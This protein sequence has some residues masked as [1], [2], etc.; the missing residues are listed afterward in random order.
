MIIVTATLE[1]VTR[2]IN[3]ND[4]HIT[5]SITQD[6][7]AVDGF[8]F[9]I[10]PTNAGFDLIQSRK[11]IIKC[12]NDRTGRVEF[13]GR[14]LLS[15][16]KMDNSGVVTKTVTC[17][18]LMGYLHDSVQPY[19]AEELYTLNDF[20]DL[21]LTNH[22]D[23]VE[24]S[25]WIFRGEVD[26]PVA[27]TG[28]VYKGLQYQTTFETLKTKLLDVYGG[29]MQV[30]ERDGVLRLDYLTQI[31][32][33]RSTPI[34]L[35]N[36]MLDASRE[37]SPLD[38]VTRVIPLGAKLKVEV[39]TENEDGSI[40]VTEEE[41]E[42]RLTLVGHALEDG[43]VM[44]VPWVDDEEK[45]DA[46]GVVVGTLD[47][48][49]VTEQYNLYAKTREW[50]INENRVNLSHTLTAID[51]KE[52]GYDL[53]GLYCGDSYPVSNKLIGLNEVLRITKKSFDI[54]EQYKGNL[55]IGEKKATLSKL[56]AST[57]ERV[58]QQLQDVK[59]E[60][61]GLGK[62]TGTLSS[63]VATL[64]T[65]LASSMTEV[66]MAA[67][68]SYVTTADMEQI[69][70]DISAEISLEAGKVSMDFVERLERTSVDV[71]G[72]LSS[73]LAELKAYIRYYM[74]EE[75]KPTIELGT[76]NSDIICTLLNDKFALILNGIP[77]AYIEAD[78][79]GVSQFFI[80]TATILQGLNLGAF[81]LK[82]RDNNNLSMIKIKG[83]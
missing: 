63:Q 77:V 28:N 45:M 30:V 32:T 74:T 36:N 73:F 12:T 81:T 31:G 6:V 69:R 3:G 2:V 16:Q 42:E 26:V 48:P 18:G 46:L 60:V 29:E 54:N 44:T 72:R 15:E 79:E 17:E 33:T 40:T 61:E 5:G 67:L 59:K 66:V 71:D 11:T 80:T 70:N 47:F 75:G 53:D 57:A 56:Q 4:Q 41:S 10:D 78:E 19:K 50:L 62:N 22:N 55:T 37:V 58:N 76:E 9:E 83:V 64:S 68:A 49:D 13:H 43:T 82:M 21:V 39:E 25:K 27:D 51:L 52:L 1:G 34:E 20:I 23:Q 24:G 7:E 65:T 8:T 35:G 38:I 14:V